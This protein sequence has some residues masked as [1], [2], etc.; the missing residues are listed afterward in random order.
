MT[1]VISW[2]AGIATFIYTR[3]V[4]AEPGMAVTVAAPALAS[5]VVFIAG[6]LV[7]PSAS[8]GAETLFAAL[9]EPAH[10]H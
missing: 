5:I 8:K 4:T 3:Y 6:G 2:I 7:E 10:D 1:A 9:E